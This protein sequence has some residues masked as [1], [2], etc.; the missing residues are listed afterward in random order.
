MPHLTILYT[1]NLDGAIEDGGADIQALCTALTETM[2]AQRDEARSA[3]FPLGGIRVL[4]YPASHYAIADSGAAGRTAGGTGEYAFVYLN[5]RV[6]RG[7]S[8]AVLERTGRA[9]DAC[10]KRHFERM[11][12]ERHIGITLQ[13]DEGD[14]V[15]NART[16]SLHPLFAQG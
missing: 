12:T 3:V 2:A 10:I 7:R 11:L 1:P 4:A 9:L 14:E 15:F 13:I 6:A 8:A 5:L 16:S